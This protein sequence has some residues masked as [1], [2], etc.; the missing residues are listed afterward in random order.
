[1]GS[2]LAACLALGFALL[3]PVFRDTTSVAS[4]P[5]LE[6]VE[7]DELVEEDPLDTIGRTEL[8]R[9]ASIQEQRAANQRASIAAQLRLMGLRPEL[10]P[11]EKQLRSV[12]IAATQP[13]APVRNEAAFLEEVQKMKPMPDPQILSVESMRPEP[14]VRWPGGFHSSLASFK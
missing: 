5:A 1:M 7:A 14:A 2:G 8:R 11:D 4:Q 3:V 12:S 13:V 9:F 10:T 6:G